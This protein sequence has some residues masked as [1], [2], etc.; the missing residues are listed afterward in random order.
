M[1]K[2]K[3]HKENSAALHMSFSMCMCCCA[4]FAALSP[5]TAALG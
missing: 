3:L 1:F 5:R 2:S 4:L